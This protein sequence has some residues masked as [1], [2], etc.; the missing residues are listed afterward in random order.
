MQ[1]GIANIILSFA[2]DDPHGAIWSSLLG[3]SASN[4]QQ[5]D[6][7]LV[8]GCPIKG[9]SVEDY[10]FLRIIVE[11]GDKKAEMTYQIPLQHVAAIVEG[12]ADVSFGFL[13]G[14]KEAKS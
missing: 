11:I 4:I 13:S 5:S 6:T 2:K 3:G 7:A 14:K 12:L 9:Y 8:I 10:H 1:K